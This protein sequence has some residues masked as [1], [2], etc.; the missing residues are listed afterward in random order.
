MQSVAEQMPSAVVHRPLHATQRL[1]N[2][3]EPSVSHFF[4]GTSRSNIICAV[5][6]AAGA[7]KDIIIK[8]VQAGRKPLRWAAHTG[9]VTAL[10]WSPVAD[11]IVSG[12]EDCT[13]RT[14]DPFG[15]QVSV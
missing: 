14:W 13:Y 11:R 4:T 8:G 12:G 6:V 3:R 9:A 15:R 5:Q 10:D 7:G 1:H 2:G